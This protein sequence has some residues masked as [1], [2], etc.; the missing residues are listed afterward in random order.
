MQNLGCRF[1]VFFKGPKS[2]LYESYGVKT[3]IKPKTYVD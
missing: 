2:Q 1:I 3:A